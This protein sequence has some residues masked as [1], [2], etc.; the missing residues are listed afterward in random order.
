MTLEVEIRPLALADADGCDAVIA[1]LPYHF[2][3]PDGRAE[4]ARSVRADP[5]LAAIHGG[6][7]VGFMTWRAWFDDAREITWL[8]VAADHR[9]G[10]IGGRLV[11]ELGEQ[12]RRAATRYLVVTT[13]SAT[14]DEPGIADGYESTRRFYRQNGFVPLWEPA[15]W[16]N[17]ENQAVVMLCDLGHA[18]S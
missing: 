16:W 2:G 3:D 5:G 8:A 14:T 9:R 13:L 10:G 12:S 11:A 1:S 6:S 4:C 17:A 18:A 15:G 7:L